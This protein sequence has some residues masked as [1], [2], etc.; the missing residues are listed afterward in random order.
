MQDRGLCAKCA[1]KPVVIK[2]WILSTASNG[3]VDDAEVFSD[4]R[5]ALEAIKQFAEE[6]GAPPDP[7]GEYGYDFGE[8]VGGSINLTHHMFVR[9]PTGKLRELFEGYEEG[10]M[11]GPFVKYPDMAKGATGQRLQIK[12][13]MHGGIKG[14]IA[15]Y[16]LQGFEV[17]H[18]RPIPTAP[19]LIVFDLKRMKR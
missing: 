4:E 15:D 1:K 6:Q 7:N 2:E 3:I 10:Q 11:G 5:K 13:Q 19:D 17:I 16:R 9:E 8:T 18:H 12:K 14:T